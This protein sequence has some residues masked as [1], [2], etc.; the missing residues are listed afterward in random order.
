MRLERYEY[1][2]LSYVDGRSE[3]AD[4][5]A[6]TYYWESYVTSM[7]RLY[8]MSVGHDAMV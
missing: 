7:L 5:G 1:H 8:N 4:L 2:L 3:L 6:N